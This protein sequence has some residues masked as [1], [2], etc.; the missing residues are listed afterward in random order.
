MLAAIQCSKFCRAGPDKMYA[1]RGG[2]IIFVICCLALC[3]NLNFNIQ[4]ILERL[5][6][7]SKISYIQKMLNKQSYF[8]LWALLLI[9]NSIAFGSS[10]VFFVGAYEGYGKNEGM[11]EKDGYTARAR[12]TF[13][14]HSSFKNS[15][16]YGLETGIQSGNVGALAVSSMVYQTLGSLPIQTTIKPT[17]DALFTIRSPLLFKHHLY[18][19]SKAG[20]AYRQLQFDTRDTIPD[21]QKVN[22]ELQLGLGFPITRNA[23]IGA[24]YQGI[25]GGKNAKVSLTSSETAKVLKIPTEQ[26][27]FIGLEYSFR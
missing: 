3:L 19:I 15:F 13:G 21:I 2:N 24:I 1:E 10:K 12:L 11:I 26:N 7:I 9:T 17:I 4:F 8:F 16:N 5:E 6:A 22:P 18:F 27:G 25:Y 14:I 20:I 23:T